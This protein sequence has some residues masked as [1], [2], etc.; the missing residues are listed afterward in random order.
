MHELSIACD[1]VEIA[2]VGGGPRIGPRRA[3]RVRCGRRDAARLRDADDDR[4]GERRGRPGAQERDR[5][6][7]PS[8]RH[9]LRPPTQ[10][11]DT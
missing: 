9:P 10:S 4:R 7:H 3:G 8:R 2:E 6:N 11:R 1:L 5:Q